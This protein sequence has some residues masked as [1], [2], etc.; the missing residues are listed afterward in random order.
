MP[1]EVGK[2]PHAALSVRPSVNRWMRCDQQQPIRS[3]SKETQPKSFL[4]SPCVLVSFSLKPFWDLVER[5][6]ND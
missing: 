3:H 1:V 4:F 6:D 2:K 5:P